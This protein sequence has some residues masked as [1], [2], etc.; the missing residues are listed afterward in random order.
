MTTVRSDSP[1]CPRVGADIVLLVSDDDGGISLLQQQIYSLQNEIQ[2]IRTRKHTERQRK[3]AAAAPPR[4]PKPVSTAPPRERKPSEPRQRSAPKQKKSG[5][6]GGG[7][8]RKQSRN[9][10]TDE[11]QEET[12]SFEMKR[13]LAVKI[14]S[15]EGDNLERAIDIIRMGRPDLL[16]VRSSF[17]LGCNAN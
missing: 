16:S 11:E 1:L 14:T 3:I 17:A 2:M 10:S 6:G 13:E 5:G 7:R 9:D 4:P 12:V 8:K 15:F